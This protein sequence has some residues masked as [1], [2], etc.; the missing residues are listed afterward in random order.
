[1]CS[2]LVIICPMC[3]SAHGTS[4]EPVSTASVVTV[5]HTGHGWPQLYMKLMLRVLQFSLAVLC[6]NILITQYREDNM[7]CVMVQDLSF[8][9]LFIPCCFILHHWCTVGKYNVGAHH[10][11]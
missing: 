4:P 3:F 6:S 2:V 10:D 1:M 11:H 8:A 9:V 5:S 7:V